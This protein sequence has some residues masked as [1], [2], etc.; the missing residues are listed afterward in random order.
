[1]IID[2]PTPSIFQEALR[3][4]PGNKALGP[5][6]IPS[7]LLTHMPPAFHKITCQL[8]QTMAITGTTPPNCLLSNTILSKKK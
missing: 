6:N 3:R 5:D 2:N 8:F 4:L 7:V 1:M